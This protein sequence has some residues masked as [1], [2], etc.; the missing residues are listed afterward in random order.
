[1]NLGGTP[2]HRSWDTCLRRNWWKRNKQAWS[3]AGPAPEP[4]LA[5]AR[6]ALFSVSELTCQVRQADIG[7]A[8]A[9][10]ISVFTA[11]PVGSPGVGPVCL[12][13]TID[14]D[15]GFRSDEGLA[16]E[17]PVGTAEVSSRTN[18]GTSD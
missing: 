18:V 7:V 17:G 15:W 4:A 12:L 2:R 16:I 13:V 1:M 6:H 11:R 5:E 10:N 3:P 14:G 8:E 9:D